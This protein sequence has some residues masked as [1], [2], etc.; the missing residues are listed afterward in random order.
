[1]RR[2]QQHEAD[3]AVTAALRTFALRVGAFGGLT[4][5][6]R[7]PEMLLIS[8]GLLA[9]AI[10]LASYTLLR[11][12]SLAHPFVRSGMAVGSS[13]WFGSVPTLVHSFAFAAFLAAALWPW[14][15]LAVGGC[16]LWLS[17]ELIL[18]IIQIDA[19]SRTIA[20]QEWLPGTVRDAVAGAGLSTFDPLDALGAVVGVALTYSLIWALRPSGVSH[21]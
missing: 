18:E 10:G 9:L 15:R 1:M 11:G 19:V 13:A 20:G 4:A 21:D 5:S 6:R 2:D 14:A 7:R 3:H 17:V 8:L 16:V 12:A